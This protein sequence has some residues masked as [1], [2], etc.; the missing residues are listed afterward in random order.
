MNDLPSFSVIVP[1]YNRPDALAKCL[2][3]LAWQDYPIDR[4]EVIVVDD[5]GT[6][7]LSKVLP[8]GLPP[9]SI[10]FL[11]QANGGPGA[12][13][14]TGAAAA[15]FPFL[16]F[17]D[18][19][20]LP[21]RDWLKSLAEALSADSDVLVGGDCVNAFPYNLCCV[22]SQTILDV[23]HA[24][25]NRDPQH[26]SF[27]P[28]DN[29]AMSRAKFL[30]I[31]GFDPA[32]RCSE[33]RDLCD[34]WSAKGWRLIRWPQAIIDH[35]REMGFAGYCRQ[36]YGYGKG[37]W[38]FHTARKQRGSGEFAVDGNFYLKCFKRPWQSESII[39]A[40]PLTLLLLTWQV[41]N[42][43]GFF[44]ERFRRRPPRGGSPGSAL[45]T[46][47]TSPTLPAK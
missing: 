7:D 36:H 37:A 1:T 2:S 13:R 3:S 28:S 32:F 40:I 10:Q 26:A 12:A 43:A 38:R 20:C 29:I 33:D 8:T 22:A 25:F 5:G 30:E 17:T 18:D 19:D 16:A 4:F 46:P 21:R 14:N 31:G 15:R 6:A 41:A 44:T 34:R 39:R 45:E 35:A 27:F 23:I 24:H 9:I 11:K 47:S 42:T